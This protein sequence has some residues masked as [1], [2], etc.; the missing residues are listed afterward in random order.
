MLRPF[1]CFFGGKWRVAPQYPS[2]AHGSIVEPFAGAAGYSTR[3]PDRKIILVEKDPIIAALW[4]YLIAVPTDE[5]RRIPLLGPDQTVDDLKVCPEAR[6]LVGFWLN[7]GT[8]RPC[9][10]QSAWMRTGTH[11]ASFWGATVRAR[12]AA[13]VEH[14]RHW[15][16]IEGS[17]E[18]APQISAT[19]FVDP[20]YQIQGKNYRCSSTQN[21]FTH[22]SAWCRS[23]QGRVIVCEQ[24]GA[25]WLPF[26]RAFS[27][28]A[29]ESKNGKGRSSEVMWFSDNNQEAA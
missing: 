3:Y 12:I 16:V 7:K 9:S 26:G 15:R 11:A 20:P 10:T 25:R 24:E 1:F 8:S 2:P 28:K 21:D 19:W 23:R 14:I 18:S 5:V 13:Q 27:I 6:S 4:R 29:N 22:L 17:Y